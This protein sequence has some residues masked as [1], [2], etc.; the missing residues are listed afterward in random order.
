MWTLSKPHTEDAKDHLETVLET[1]DME[2]PGFVSQDEL[3]Q[4]LAIY[5]RYEQVL[6][7][8]EDFLEGL[9]IRPELRSQVRNSY[10]HVQRDG[11]LEHLR[12]RLMLAASECPYCGFGPIEDLDHHLLKSIY[13][14]LSIFAL[15][16]VPCCA[17]CNRKK[18]K[19]RAGLAASR[20][21]NVYLEQIA[22]I[23]FFFATTFLD[24][25]SGGLLV[26]FEI[27]ESAD[28]PVEMADRL[29][30]QFHLFDLDAR[31]RKQSNI[32]LNSLRVAFE[33]ASASGVEGKGMRSFLQRSA[34]ANE[35]SFGVNDW[36]SA[37]LTALA[38]NEEFCR[39]GFRRALG[40][41]V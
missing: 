6:G 37:L 18:P 5:A 35:Q 26:Q 25:L 38:S 10:K 36:R 32:F 12:E 8:G 14:P 21:L 40:E 1:H 4:V 33:D 16:L 23:R 24:Q 29:K 13:E 9:T 19:S 34:R 2:D 28:L 20:T 15:N 7:V 39:G 41:V 3:A 31:L 22:D 11:K 30:E 27:R 17:T